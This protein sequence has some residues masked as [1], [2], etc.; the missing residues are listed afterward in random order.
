MAIKLPT[1]PPWYRL[2]GAEKHD[3]EAICDRILRL[4]NVPKVGWLGSLRLD[5]TE[6]EKKSYGAPAA[7]ATETAS[8][9]DTATASATPAAAATTTAAAA[10]SATLEAPATTSTT[11]GGA[12][13]QDSSRKRQ[14]R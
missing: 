2:F 9:K 12:A 6:E 1:S 11:A 7:S 5:A 3:I 8:A 13:E 10:S 14:R 4:Y